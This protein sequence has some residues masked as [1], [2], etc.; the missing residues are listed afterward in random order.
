MEHFDAIVIGSGFGG[1]VAACRLS[2]AGFRVLV[3]E[4]G[5]RYESADFPAL[6]DDDRLLPDLRR[7]VWSEEQGLWDLRDLGEIVT[8]QAAGYGGGSLIYANVHLRPPKEAFNDKHW[9][10]RFQDGALE[11]YFDL[12]AYMLNVSPI[13]E[14]PGEEF[15][16]TAVLRQ[17][18]HGLGRKSFQPPLA[19]SYS[20]GPNAFGE[21]Q[22]SCTGCGKCATGCPSRAKNT[23]DHNY[24]A[25]AEQNGAV[26]RTQCEVTGIVQGAA[27]AAEQRWTVEYTDHLRAIQVPV[28]AR[29][30]FVCAGV[31]NSTRLL[32]GAKLRPECREVKQ[33]VG[34]GYFPNADAAGMVYDTKDECFPSEGPC[35]TTGAVHWQRD[36]AAGE[37]ER[38]ERFFMIQ[39]GGY[40]P[41]LE[42]LLGVLRAPLWSG[43]NRIHDAVRPARAPR[44]T[45]REPTP[46]SGVA[47]VSPLDGLLDAAAGNALVT[48]LPTAL[49]ASWEGFLRELERPL[50]MPAIVAATIERSSRARYERLPRWVKKLFRYGSLPVR[51]FKSTFEWFIGFVGGNGEVG[52]HA[53][54]GLLK[55]SDLDRKAYVRDIFGYDASGATRRMMLLAM[56]EDS[57]PGALLFD[58][59][60]GMVADLDLYHLIP[61]FTEQELLM[62]DLARELG[63]EL[64]LNPAWSFFGKPITVH[65]LGGCTMSKEPA[66]GV[67]RP[68]GQVHGCPGLYVMDGSVLC[69]SVGVNPT[70]TI[71]AISE[72]N[73]LDFI[74]AERGD[75]WPELPGQRPPG[76]A[77]YLEHVRGARDW[78]KR[79]T[80]RGWQLRFEPE[81]AVAV[82][83]APLGLRFQ[84]KFHGYCAPLK[85]GEDPIA[86]EGDS[87]RYRSGVDA[88]HRLFEIRGRP[89]H[90]FSLE[91]NVSC[92]NL[93]RFFE[94]MTH[95]LELEG[96]LE[97]HLP[98][99]P[100]SGEKG[101]K[102][103]GY[104]ELL[105]PRHKPY[106]VSPKL[107]GE[108]RA[109]TGRPHRT[110][111]GNPSPG[112]PRF[113]YYHL[114]LPED[115]L[116]LEGYKRIRNDPGL[117]AWRDTTALFTRFGRPRVAGSPLGSPIDAVA[118]GVVHVNLTD[119]AYE[120]MPSFATI[121]GEGALPRPPGLEV[122]G[123]QDPA[124]VT[125]ALGKFM[126]FFFGTLQRIYSPG[127]R[128]ASSA[129]FE[130]LPNGVRHE[131]PRLRV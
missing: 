3:L 110:R 118:A 41:E 18:T 130:P 6:P 111:K 8:V 126:A 19:I 83:S 54:Q 13:S 7:W 99:L 92:V 107:K 124:R 55:G 60:L 75:N 131:R 80:A 51:L 4:R 72:L 112:A 50:L 24:L 59:K 122:T 12:A 58:R 102:V 32:R 69:R 5:R 119:F 125:W 97:F 26:A 114:A 21:T 103:R 105:V 53:L 48:T 78:Q 109:I 120:E 43:R 101:T 106:G 17:A 65:S 25:I 37:D 9:P 64:R 67:T 40:A 89:E 15:K 94:D 129:L 108:Q 90:A 38:K 36:E 95:R 79:A 88:A 29:N 45:P 33:R 100:N 115:V 81:P 34:L 20:D 77:Q 66:N 104:L 73:I 98:G 31:V 121:G 82:Q 96:T 61:T 68:D 1:A 63:G 22:G 30:V 76:A 42:R 71:L 74:R 16:K 70:P 116:R 91:L 52:H 23:L 14:R 123:T 27:D 57:A 128:A 44:D 113:M 117:D 85:P 49:R 84:E 11:D 35:I 86:G 127:A 39:D 62:K 93:H 10:A 28:T 47:L 46:M 2:Q 56:G 87:K